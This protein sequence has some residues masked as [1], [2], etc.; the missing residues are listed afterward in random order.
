MLFL[1]PE[2]CVEL[3]TLIQRRF[4]IPLIYAICLG[5]GGVDCLMRE[6]FLAVTQVPSSSWPSSFIEEYASEGGLCEASYPPS[7]LEFISK[8]TQMSKRAS[9]GRGKG[10]FLGLIGLGSLKQKVGAQEDQAFGSLEP[11]TGRDI[12]VR[13]TSHGTPAA[14]YR[15]SV[16]SLWL[17]CLRF[18][19]KILLPQRQRF[20]YQLTLRSC[21]G[22]GR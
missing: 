18:K 3:Y 10:N 21:G 2:R 7:P 9:L 14:S 15:E 19:G 22:R 20:Q 12:T 6:G 13:G 5:F 11:N 1:K 8:P 17:C 4:T 16:L